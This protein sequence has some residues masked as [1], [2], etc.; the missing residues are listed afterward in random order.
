MFKNNTF[1]LSTL[2]FFKIS[3]LC[4]HLDPDQRSK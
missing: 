4:K 2:T 1:K 3:V